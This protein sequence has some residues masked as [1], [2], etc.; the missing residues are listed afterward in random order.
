MKTK[1]TLIELLVVI[2]I[3]A[4]LAGML[5]PALNKARMT[6]Q[7]A[8][9]LNNIKQCGL[10]LFQYA[11]DNSDLVVSV[12]NLNGTDRF[13]PVFLT[14]VTLGNTTFAKYIGGE[15][16]ACPAELRIENA[17]WNLHP[18]KRQGYATY[19]HVFDES[20]SAA[21]SVAGNFA[22]PPNPTESSSG[23]M[24]RL[25]KV[26][27]PSKTLLLGDGLHVN[28]GTDRNT[29]FFISSTANAGRYYFAWRR[30]NNNANML[31]FD[32]HAEAMSAGQL[33]ECALPIKNSFEG[34]QKTHTQL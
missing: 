7:S 8:T 23:T 3:I 10:G 15:V 13:W 29:W 2:A 28:G 17:G 22:F 11:G 4:I 31:S 27:F 5:L 12:A 6:A 24:F 30:H 9:C 20:Y 25:N 18:K 14:G 1:F 16:T 32:G 33:N 26:R 19:Y 34:S 21:K